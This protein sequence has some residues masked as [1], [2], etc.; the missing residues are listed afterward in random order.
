MTLVG[1]VSVAAIGL[2]LTAALPRLLGVTWRAVLL[3]LSAIPV[4]AL[5]ALF[6][7]WGAGLLVHV[8]VLVAALPG[9]KV[10]QGLMLNISGS[11]VSNVLPF[12]GPAGMALGYAMTR[13]WGFESEAFA[14]FTV[15]T[16]LWNAVGKFLASVLVLAAATILGVGLPTG[17]NTALLS[18]VALVVVMVGAAV[19]TF[20]SRSAT[21]W[22]GGRLDALLL[23]IRPGH[24]NRCATWLVTTRER[25]LTVLVHRWLRMTTGVGVYLALQGALLLACLGAAG[26]R[27]T[28][29]VVAIA[30]AVDRLISLAPVTPGAAGIAE[31]GTA[32]AL[33]A[34]G[35]D[36]VAAAAGVLLYRFF[37][38][39]LEIPV[40]GALA[41]SWLRHR[42]RAAG[43]SGQSTTPA[44]GGQTPRA[45]A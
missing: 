25:L 39:A 32:T 12:G 10:R 30:F 19:A 1:S 2:G 31:V 26:A 44:R 6:V 17:V 40:G 9:L 8:T 37:T 34:L 13:G 23:R 41:V 33:A 45:I 20:R 42:R 38:F 24:P 22:V 43:R 15:A 7:L 18:A 21:E 36:P 14:S 29:G 28:V 4:G 27:P 16:N 5:T 11:A 35:V 3:E